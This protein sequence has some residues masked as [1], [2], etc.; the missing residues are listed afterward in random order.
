MKTYVFLSENGI[1]NT[2]H[3]AYETF[4][5]VLLNGVII[6]WKFIKTSIVKH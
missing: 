4:Y 2:L 1:C 5:Q 3:C 6:A